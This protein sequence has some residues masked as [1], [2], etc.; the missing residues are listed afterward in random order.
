MSEP[1]ASSERGAGERPGPG[2]VR[3]VVGTPAAR[4]P[5]AVVWNLHVAHHALGLMPPNPDDHVRKRVG[6]PRPG[7]R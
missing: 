1:A 5:L 4:D 3:R 2:S 6:R 7:A